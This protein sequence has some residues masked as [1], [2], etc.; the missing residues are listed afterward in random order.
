MWNYSALKWSCM[1]YKSC[2]FFAM[3]PEFLFISNSNKLTLTYLLF[4]FI[5]KVKIDG[6]FCDY[7]VF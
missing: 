4:L 7:I 2:K 1:L 6:R 5:R 3:L